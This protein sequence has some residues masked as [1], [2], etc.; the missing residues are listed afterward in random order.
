MTDESCTITFKNSCCS[1]TTYQVAS[2]LK[3]GLFYNTETFTL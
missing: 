3:S 1:I 2:A